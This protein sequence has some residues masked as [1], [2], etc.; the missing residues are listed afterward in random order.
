M[1]VSKA[2]ICVMACA[3]MFVSTSIRANEDR[4]YSPWVNDD[5]PK[6]VYFGDTHLHTS[7][8]TDAGMIANTLGPSD[9]GRLGTIIPPDAPATW[10]E[11]A[12]SSPVWYTP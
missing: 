7:Y 12:Y 11:R 4:H 5:Y 8:S 9:A 3:L 6:Q 10:V 1:L 2:F